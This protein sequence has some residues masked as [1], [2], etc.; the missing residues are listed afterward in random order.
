MNLDIQINETFENDGL[1]DDAVFEF[2]PLPPVHAAPQPD[3]RHHLDP[4]LEAA[5]T[6]ASSPGRPRTTPSTID[7]PDLH[8]EIDP[9]A[10]YKHPDV[11]AWVDWI[12]RLPGDEKVVHNLELNDD[13]RDRFPHGPF[14]W[15]ENGAEEAVYRAAAFAEWL[16]QVRILARAEAWSLEDADRFERAL[17]EFAGVPE[18]DH[19]LYGEWLVL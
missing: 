17:V 11:M 4:E 16:Q 13:F 10:P 2:V 6:T 18:E 8:E 5:S 3:H 1:E 15:E 9:Q 14:G 19:P 7:D 12:E